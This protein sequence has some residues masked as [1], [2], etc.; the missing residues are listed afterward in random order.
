VISDQT[1]NASGHVIGTFG[2]I[3]NAS[4]PMV[5]G[6]SKYHGVLLGPGYSCPNIHAPSRP[7]G[8]VHLGQIAGLV[9]KCVT[10]LHIREALTYQPVAHYWP[11]QW[12]ESAIFLGAALLLGGLSL[13]RVRRRLA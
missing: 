2:S 12:C 9:Q 11:L 1:I 13:W 6:V 5:T 7:G 3:G 4:T 8:S 10:Q